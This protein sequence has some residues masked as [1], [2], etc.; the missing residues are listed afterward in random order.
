MVFF[1]KKE[2]SSQQ[3]RE[4]IQI[5]AH[6][7][8]FKNLKRDGNVDLKLSIAMTFFSRKTELAICWFGNG[9][10]IRVCQFNSCMQY[11]R[12]DGNDLRPQRFRSVRVAMSKLP[13]DLPFCSN[14]PRRGV[15]GNCVG[16]ART[17]QDLWVSVISVTAV[18]E[19]VQYM[20]L[21]P[22][23]MK[24]FGLMS[25]EF[26][27]FTLAVVSTVLFKARTQYCWRY[28]C[29]VKQPRNFLFPRLIY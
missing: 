21:Q 3:K 17:K 11:I 27:L 6:G 2:N 26:S 1:L 24:V 29:S 20:K 15:E 13:S 28:I 22:E 18:S 25:T 9:L 12:N 19:D 14:Q 5:L 23:L 7:H 8:V 10:Y 4:I 16:S